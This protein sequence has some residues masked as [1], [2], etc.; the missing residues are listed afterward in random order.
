MVAILHPSSSP[1]REEAMLSQSRSVML[2]Y[3]QFPV[4]P[5]ISTSTLD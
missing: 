3:T 5:D 4:N 1:T 2:S